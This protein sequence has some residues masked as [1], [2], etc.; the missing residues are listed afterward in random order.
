[1]LDLFLLFGSLYNY[2]FTRDTSSKVFAETV[3]R[4]ADNGELSKILQLND[5]QISMFLRLKMIF[6]MAPILNSEN[7]L[8]CL[9]LDNQYQ[10]LDVKNIVGFIFNNELYYQMAK[11]LIHPDMLEWIS[12]QHLLGSIIIAPSMYIKQIWDEDPD[13]KFYKD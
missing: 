11:G 2:T 6:N 13:Y 1:M 7:Q 8:D 12:N 4:L 9:Y 10:N 3:A 5:E